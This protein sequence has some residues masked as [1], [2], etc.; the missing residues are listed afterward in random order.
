MTTK[1]FK[2]SATLLVAVLGLGALFATAGWLSRS[3]ATNSGT[4][5]TGF[6]SLG[7]N[8]IHDANDRVASLN[9][10]ARLA[11]RGDETAVR[12]LADAVFAQFASADMNDA[13]SVAK[14][15]L[16]T[17]EVNYRRDGEGGISENKLVKALNKA[18][19]QLGA[20]D[21]ARVSVAQLRYLRVSLL[22]VYPSLIGQSH[23]NQVGRSAV[24]SEMSP[25]EAAGLSMLLFTQKVSNQD[26]QV[27]PKEWAQKRHEE[28]IARWEAHRSGRVI[29]TEKAVRG[30]AAKETA[31]SKELQ[32]ILTSR[33][34]DI[35]PLV[36]GLLTE[37]G[38]S[39]EGRTKR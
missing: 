38:M 22:A 27:T 39:A 25:L 6:A 20:P 4:T 1:H 37:M 16:V 18:S 26:F 29:P 2:K 30:S 12:D 7:L 31:K 9:S 14:D 3:Q 21:F 34:A 17:S 15:R 32:Q 19:E 11:A 13:L 35:G 5:K 24:K 28:Q 10:K 23:Q 36:D 8:S 33:A